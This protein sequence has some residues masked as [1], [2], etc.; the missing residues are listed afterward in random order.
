MAGADQQAQVEGGVV[1]ERCGIELIR[2]EGTSIAGIDQLHPEQEPAAADLANDR[3]ALE[4]RLE[5]VAKTGAPVAD[6]VDQVMLDEDVQHGEPDGAG[7][8]GSV[9]GVAEIE[10]S[11]ALRDRVENVLPA[12]H[13]RQWGI[14]RGQSLANRDDVRLDRQLM[15]RQPAADP[16]HSRH[17]LVEANQKPVS[18]RAFLESLPKS[19]GWRVGGQGRRAHRLT[20]ERRDRLG[21]HALDDAVQL[22]QCGFAG[23][24][25]PRRRGREVEGFGKI[26]LIRP[27]VVKSHTPSPRSMFGYAR[28]RNRGKT[29][30]RSAP[31]VAVTS[32]P[33]AGSREPRSRDMR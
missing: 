10:L 13:R 8:R 25:K 3:R 5:L 15:S 4:G 18:P 22:G 1:D 19:L 32:S 7:E 9:P 12:E 28:S 31:T 21:S 26:G 17:D 33:S 16:P 11:R 14:A 6:A 30:V 24:V 2:Q 20:E 27:S 29:L 23:G